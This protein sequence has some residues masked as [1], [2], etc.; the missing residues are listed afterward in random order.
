MNFFVEK[1]SFLYSTKSNVL[2]DI[3]VCTIIDL[4][5]HTVIYVVEAI[6]ST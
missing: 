4:L 1:I 5:S 6:D 3:L 2:N